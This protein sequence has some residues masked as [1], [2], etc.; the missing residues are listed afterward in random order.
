MVCENITV[1]IGSTDS[2]ERRDE[3]HREG[4]KEGTAPVYEYLRKHGGKFELKI[5]KTVSYKDDQE[6]REVEL[7]TINDYVANGGEVFN[8]MGVKVEDKKQLKVGEYKKP[9]E[10]K[11]GGW[12]V[13]KKNMVTFKYSINGKRKEK[14]WRI[15]KKRTLDEAKALAEKFQ[16]EVYE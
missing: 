2:A 9:N 12:I 13:E 14:A 3:E 4:V 16:R 11:L 8:I 5:I 10:K 7:K 1:Y 15:C 6:L